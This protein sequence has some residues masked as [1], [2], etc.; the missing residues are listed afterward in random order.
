MQQ[1]NA[2]GE[3]SPDRVQ[4]APAK[5][6][7]YQEI[8]RPLYAAIQ[9]LDDLAEMLSGEAENLE[10]IA[11][12]LTGDPFDGAQP[13]S[14]PSQLAPT[15]PIGEVPALHRA[16]ARCLDQCGRIERARRQIG[17]A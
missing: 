12:R 15:S 14:P 8:E 7:A 16:I 9:R 10:G 17:G 2:Q 1:I 11:H 13:P 3:G 6:S 5:Q 4:H